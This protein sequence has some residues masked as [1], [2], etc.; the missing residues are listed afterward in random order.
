MVD[1]RSVLRFTSAIYEF[2]QL[3]IAGVIMPKPLAF[4][5]AP[6]T[7]FQRDGAN[8][9]PQP[10]IDVCERA[11]GRRA[12]TTLN[13]VARLEPGELREVFH[14][15]VSPCLLGDVG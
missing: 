15:V 6:M 8:A 10:P 11:N 5:A 7:M 3:D 9:E 1:V 4:G 14:V 13:H 12:V 2:R